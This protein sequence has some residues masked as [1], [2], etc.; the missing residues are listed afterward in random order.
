M[1]LAGTRATYAVG[2]DKRSPLV[3]AEP[4]EPF[5]EGA[6]WPNFWAR[7]TPAYVAEIRAFVEVAR[8]ERP[9]PC[10][11]EDAVEAFYVAEA[12]DRSLRERRRVAVD[13]VRFA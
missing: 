1:E 6:P 12:A 7:F 2:L 5:P 9:S 13:E 11:V 10:T 3:S 4:G 8:G